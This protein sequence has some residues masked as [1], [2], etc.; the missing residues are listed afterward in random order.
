MALHVAG[1][2]VGP[3]LFPPAG[4]QH[5]RQARGILVKQRIAAAITHRLPQGALG[6]LE[7][8]VVETIVGGDAGA[9]VTHQSRFLQ[10]GQMGGHARLRQASDGGQL[11]DG[12]LLA[13][14]Q[15]EQAHAGR[16]GK[17][18][19]LGGPGFQIHIYLFIRI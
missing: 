1:D 9:A 6:R 8:F 13:C 16:V 11:G 15:C 10:F 19:E 5:G 17:D 18:L 12:E 3:V 4:G 7:A 2:A 14:K